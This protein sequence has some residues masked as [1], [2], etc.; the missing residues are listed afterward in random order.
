MPAS[1]AEVVE[2]RPR[3]APRLSYA[4]WPVAL[5]ND[6]VGATAAP[7][8]DGPPT[9]SFLLGGFFAGAACGEICGEV[10]PGVLG[11]EPE[12]PI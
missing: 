1:E 11:L 2:E 7:F 12:F 6:A 5:S 8:A 3:E 10:G 4:C 9:D